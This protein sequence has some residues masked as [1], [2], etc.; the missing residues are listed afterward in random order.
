MAR[1]L[2]NEAFA[3]TPFDDTALVDVTAGLAQERRDEIDEAYLALTM[4]LEDIHQLCENALKNREDA[5]VLDGLRMSILESLGSI[6]EANNVFC[7]AEV[8]AVVESSRKAVD[9]LHASYALS[10]IKSVKSTAARTYLDARTE[11]LFGKNDNR[12]SKT[13]KT[14]LKVSEKAEE[15]EGIGETEESRAA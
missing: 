2:D 3:K 7:V 12:L 4:I 9:T 15:V 5:S 11:R 6:V 14:H 8:R 13:V 1:H 10:M